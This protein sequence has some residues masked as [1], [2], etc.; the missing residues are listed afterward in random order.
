MRASV[1]AVLIGW[2]DG[3]NRKHLYIARIMTVRY[4]LGPA[5]PVPAAAV[6]REG[7][8]LFIVTWRL[9]YHGG[10]SVKSIG[11]ASGQR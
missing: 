8:A 5:N 7:Q 2:S 11:K 4:Q 10:N 9:G 6:I 3:V 1:I